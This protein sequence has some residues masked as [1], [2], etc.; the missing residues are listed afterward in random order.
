MKCN[1][2]RRS[3]QKTLS[4]QD[5]VLVRTNANTFKANEKLS[6]RQNTI[7]CNRNCRPTAD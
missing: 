3:R 5:N 1:L 2:K 4:Y 6:A 7:I